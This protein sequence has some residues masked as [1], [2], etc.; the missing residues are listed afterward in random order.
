MI[1]WDFEPA[2]YSAC[3]F[4]FK[5]FGNQFDFSFAVCVKLWP[6][7]LKINCQMCRWF[8]VV[9]KLFLPSYLLCLRNECIAAIQVHFSTEPSP[10]ASA[11]H[12]LSFLRLIWLPKFSQALRYHQPTHSTI[13]NPHYSQL[14]CWDYQ[15]AHGHSS[16]SWAISEPLPIPFL[17]LCFRYDPPWNYF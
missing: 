7:N 4:D 15:M 12:S 17:H 2:H 16:G 6:N 5:M 11:S 9:F 10:L 14:S 13:Q 1:I 3:N 8:H